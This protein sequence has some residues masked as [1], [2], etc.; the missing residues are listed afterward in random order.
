[1]R[2]VFRHVLTDFAPRYL[3]IHKAF[4]PRFSGL[5]SILVLHRVVARTEGP[6]IANQEELE[7][8]PEFLESLIAFFKDADYEIVS[9]D[10]VHAR[11]NGEEQPAQKFVCFTFDDGYVDA[12]ATVYPIFKRH[13]LPFAL[14]VTTSFPDRTAVLWWYLLEDLVRTSDRVAFSF[15]GKS[16]KHPAADGAQ[17]E[18]A[19]DAIASLITNA[20]ESIREDLLVSIFESEGMNLY[21]YSERLTMDWAQIEDLSKDP[22]VTIGAHTVNH[23][24][25]SRLDEAAV[26]QEVLQ[27]KAAIERHI[28]KS[29]EHF[30]YPYGNNRA[31]GGRELKIARR[32]GFKTCATAITA[33]VFKEHARHL[34]CLPRITIT[35]GANGLF[36]T[37]K[38]T[39]GFLPALTHRFRRVVTLA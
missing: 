27:A 4:A 18:A 26:E 8:S 14:Y 38:L 16:Y 3:R 1:M 36:Q 15:G 30:A 10:Q 31:I 22:L 5:G 7:V 12:Y 29:V 19:F 37:E 25:L 2:R 13:G 34:E 20:D 24:A 35:G 6:R 17:K 32:A 11:L 28:G 33:N 39:S 21:F 9:L 23:F